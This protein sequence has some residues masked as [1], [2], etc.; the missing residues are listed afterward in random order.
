MELGSWSLV[1]GTW[2]LEFGS[3]NLVLGTWLLELGSWNL[4]LGTWLLELGHSVPYRRYS[5]SGLIVS[6]ALLANRIASISA[7]AELKAVINGILSS[8]ARRL[9]A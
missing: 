1:L 6:E 5:W 3:W 4:V 8:I 2:L 9:I 7:R